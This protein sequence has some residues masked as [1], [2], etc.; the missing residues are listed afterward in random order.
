MKASDAV[1]QRAQQRATRW[2]LPFIERRKQGLSKVF[3]QVAA[4]L[5]FSADGVRIATRDGQLRPSL[6]TAA[7]RL[8]HIAAGEGDPL[9][10]A[11]DL[12]SGDEVVDCTYG[13]GRDAV[14]AAHIV[15]PSG[16]ITAL[17][18]SAALFYMA[19]E[20]EPLSQFDGGIDA[21]PAPVTLVHGDARV[22]LNDPAADSADVVLIDPMF[23]TPKSSDAS[24]GLLRSL[25]DDG[26]LDQEWVDAAKRVARRCVVVKTGRWEPWFDAVGL[27]EVHS[28]GN[29]RWY[30]AD[31]S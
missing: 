10:R 21:E 26:S 16:S 14:V 18:A 31:S 28:W 3:D 30:R 22:W 23:E 11:A 25:A 15:G 6:S 12:R 1:Q 13:L 7:I 2:D 27:V 4:A 29:A 24:F 17:E 5:M 8:R 20:N 9:I 19:N